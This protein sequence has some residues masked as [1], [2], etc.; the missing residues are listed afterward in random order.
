MII[1]KTEVKAAG[2]E[3]LIIRE[4]TG[5]SAQIAIPR[6]HPEVLPYGISRPKY[7]LVLAF[8]LIEFLNED[9][10]VVRYGWSYVDTLREPLYQIQRNIETVANSLRRR[11]VIKRKFKRKAH[12]FNMR[13]LR[14]L[15]VTGAS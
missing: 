15:G 9:K 6:S 5:W 4:I 10:S 11:W 8:G 14:K 7:I 1:S 3:C 13:Q 12:V 2:F